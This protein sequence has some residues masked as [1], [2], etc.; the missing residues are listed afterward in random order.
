MLSQNLCFFYKLKEVDSDIVADGKVMKSEEKEKQEEKVESVKLS[1]WRRSK[2]HG[3]NGF[4][5]MC[6]SNRFSLFN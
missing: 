6:R 1:I 5:L 2:S 4:S 3:Y